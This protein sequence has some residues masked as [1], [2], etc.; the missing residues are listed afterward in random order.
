MH[1]YNL[2]T[3]SSLRDGVIHTTFTGACVFTGEE[4]TTEA[5]PLK[6]VTDGL[7]D[8][9][10]GALLQDAFPFMS[11]DDREFIKTGISPAGWATLT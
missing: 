6:A 8:Y 4:F 9:E 2:T 11:P 5:Y 10:N 1:I 3:T 7:R